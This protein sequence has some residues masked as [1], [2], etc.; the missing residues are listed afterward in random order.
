MIGWQLL[1]F[2]IP[3]EATEPAQ[4][5]MQCVICHR[6]GEAQARAA[7]GQ[8]ERRVR[9]KTFKDIPCVHS[10]P[11]CRWW[12]PGWWGTTAR[13]QLVVAEEMVELSWSQG[14]VVSP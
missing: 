1:L 11:L 3:E 2:K 13:T 4:F 8:D 12:V 7:Q 5:S 10:I 9:G 6:A 14:G